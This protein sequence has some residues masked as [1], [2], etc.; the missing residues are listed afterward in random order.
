MLTDT[1]CCNAK[2]KGKPFKLVDGNGLC[3]EVKPNGVK[4]WR[5]RFE[6]REG[7]T[8]K[9]GLFA[10]ATTSLL[11]AAKRRRMPRHD[12]LAVALRWPRR[13]TSA[14]RHGY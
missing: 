3:L 4:T 13:G 7:E 5:Y 10:V 8:V 1:Q 14:P 11:R 12:V 6:F 9:E 2:L